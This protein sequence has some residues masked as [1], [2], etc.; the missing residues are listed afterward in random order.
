MPPATR[1]P[2][3]DAKHTAHWFGLAAEADEPREQWRLLELGIAAAD[4]RQLIWADRRLR[5][6]L[7]AIGG[8]V[9]ERLKKSVEKASKEN[10]KT[11]FGVRKPTGLLARIVRP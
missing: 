10:E 3:S 4:R 2:H 6:A 7:G 11:L 8:N 1:A 5:D 9:P